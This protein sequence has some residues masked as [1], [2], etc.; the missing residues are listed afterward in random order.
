QSTLSASER[1]QIEA[2]Q[3]AYVRWTFLGSGMTHPQFL[4]TVSDL[5]TDGAARVRAVAEPFHQPQH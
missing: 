5:S 2:Q 4:A 3:K 1:E